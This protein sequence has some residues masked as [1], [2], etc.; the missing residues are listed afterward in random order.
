ML[1]SPKVARNFNCCFL[2][3][4]FQ[5]WI[6]SLDQSV[7]LRFTTDLP[8]FLGDWWAC[9]QNTTS[10]S[11]TPQ[12]TSAPP[13]TCEAHR[14]FANLNWCDSKPNLRDHSKTHLHWFNYRRSSK[15][16]TGAASINSTHKKKQKTNCASL[17]DQNLWAY[18][19]LK[20]SD[21]HPKSIP[22]ET[23]DSRASHRT[24]LRWRGDGV[25]SGARHLGRHN[26]AS[27]LGNKRD[28]RWMEGFCFRSPNLPHLA[29][30]NSTDQFRPIWPLDRIGNCLICV[31]NTLWFQ[32][33]RLELHEMQTIYEVKIKIFVFHI[34]CS[35]LNLEWCLC[36]E[37]M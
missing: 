15:L 31:R 5:P 19:M 9:F 30:R 18:V 26:A 34:V 27:K 6:L 35:L 12:N 29:T 3:L 23:L 14:C 11:T 21:T 1:T 22:Q 33:S 13:T 4:L 2:R 17:Q 24:P 32:V 28:L 37:H 8:A 36:V 25:E 16:E 7:H 10:F 20:A